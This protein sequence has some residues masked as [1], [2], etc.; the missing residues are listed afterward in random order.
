MRD[1][2][3][4]QQEIFRTVGYFNGRVF[5]KIVHNVETTTLASSRSDVVRRQKNADG[6]RAPTNYVAKATHSSRGV[7]SYS[8]TQNADARFTYEGLGYGHLITTNMLDVP[9]LP[10][11]VISSTLV[12]AR[13]GLNSK[14]M[15]VGV[16]LLEARG[17]MDLI[18]SSARRLASAMSAVVRKDSKGI[19]RALGVPSV[20]K[21]A[22]T[23]ADLW[24]Q[25]NFGW[26]P[27]VSDIVG[28]CALL[29]DE[30][31]H[32]KIRLN[33]RSRS[34]Q[35]FKTTRVASTSTPDGFVRYKVTETY[36]DKVEYSVSLWYSL[37]AEELRRL[38]QWGGTDVLGTAWAVV[39]YSFIADWVLP[40]GD[41]LEAYSASVGLSYRGGTSTIFKERV[42]T[43]TGHSPSS[44]TWSVKSFDSSFPKLRGVD[45][46]RQVFT[47]EPFPSPLYVKDPF[48]TWRT[49][50]SIAL[51]KNFK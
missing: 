7:V 40:I 25:Y 41:V 8:R 37:V 14:K 19:A 28:A 39:P 45:M 4:V 15:E 27:I 1:Y 12:Q 34:Y 16:A 50:T 35:F 18:G 44:P 2:N 31:V 11:S 36:K 10:S 46:I 6:W 24:L 47:N 49:I 3:A 48:S 21:A 32:R 23:S 9:P 22:V 20:K 5:D 51:L 38:A 30:E 13:K 17:A 26:A 43:A 42:V 29:S 33:A